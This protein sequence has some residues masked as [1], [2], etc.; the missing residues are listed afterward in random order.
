MHLHNMNAHIDCF[1]KK[2]TKHLLRFCRGI[3]E[4]LCS[5]EVM[6]RKIY[7][8]SENQ[9]QFSLYFPYTK[10]NHN[11]FFICMNYYYLWGTKITYMFPCIDTWRWKRR[12][13]HADSDGDELYTEG[14]KN[15]RS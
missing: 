2:V 12:R 13:K 8:H 5:C 10:S 15:D 7:L 4:S 1:L 9:T 11:F 6:K 3:T 14:I